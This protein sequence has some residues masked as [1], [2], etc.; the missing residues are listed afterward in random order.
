ME[1]VAA[2]TSVFGIAFA[3]FFSRIRQHDPDLGVVGTFF[4]GAG[5][6][7]SKGTRCSATSRCCGAWLHWFILKTCFF[8]FCFC[9]RATFRGTATTRSCAR[10]K[11]FIPSRWSGCAP[12]GDVDLQIGP[13]PPE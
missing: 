10:W 8:L 6:R 7:R 11:V 5:C 13:W 9:G 1:I 3:L 4:L 12:S 2:S